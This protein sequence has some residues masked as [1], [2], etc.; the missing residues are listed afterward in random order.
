MNGMAWL[1]IAIVAEVIAT[2][3][4]KAS[5]GFR[6]VAPSVITTIGYGIAFWCMS[7]A[8]RTVPVGIV[9]ALWSGV[10]IVLITSIAWILYRQQIDTAG[11]I[12]IGLILAGVVVIQ[13]F[14]K[15]TA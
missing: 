6:N 9:Y 2:T 3:A 7:Q 10:G 15:T 5:D 1:A 13:V 14:S 8:M 4:L 12:G 11:L